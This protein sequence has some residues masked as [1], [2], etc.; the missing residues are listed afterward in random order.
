M[1]QTA[2]I[3]IICK[4]PREGSSKTRLHGVLDP[5]DAAE[6]AG[7]FLADVASAITAIPADVGRRCYAIYAPE[8]SEA[9]LRRFV[10]TDFGL[11]CQRDSTLG[12]VLLGATQALLDRGH[13]C[14][15]LV[16]ADSPT[17]PTRQ[18]EQA[19]T[20][21]RAPGDRVV[22]GPATDGG[23][24]L[25]GLK[26]PHGH[27][28]DDIAWSSPSVLRQTMDRAG[29]VDLEVKLL[30]PWYDVDDAGT[31]TTLLDEVLRGL[32][33]V[34]CRGQTG[35]AALATRRFI[36]CHPDLDGRVARVMGSGGE[37]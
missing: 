17:L 1:S 11:H 10:P 23:Y 21:L 22:L 12:V 32:L 19:I 28:F 13:D 24:Y 30:A 25:I 36:A 8:G 4:T 18:L 15:I 2:G 16:N 27:L 7:C 33:P 29:E 5:R 6:L 9:E 26:H 37:T 34:A 35:G 20:I 3:G 31:L 14:A